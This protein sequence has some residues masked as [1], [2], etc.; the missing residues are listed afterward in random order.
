MSSGN[1]GRIITSIS[2]ALLTIFFLTTFYSFGTFGLLNLLGVRTVMQIFIILMFICLCFTIQLRITKSKLYGAL[3]F[4]SVYAL[5]SLAHGGVWVGPVEAFLGFF[6]FVVIM[7]APRKHIFKVAKV[8]VF[9]TTFFCILVVIAYL[10]YR[11][12]PQEFSFANF[13]IYDS[14]VGSE[15]IHPGHIVDWLSFT[16]GDGF[17]AG[18]EVSPR[19]KGYSNEP[20]STIVHYLAPAIFA[21]LLGGR[22][23]FLG[24]FILTVSVVAIASFTGHI[25]IGLAL[26]LSLLVLFGRKNFQLSVLV[27]LVLILGVI[28]QLDR[29]IALFMFFGE[30][31]IESAGIDLI[32]RKLG[33]GTGPSTLEVRQSGMVDGLRA[34]VFAPIGYSVDQLGAGAGLL[35]IISANMGWIGVLMA[36][37][38][39]LG[40]SRVATQAASSSSSLRVWFATS[41]LFSIL[42]VS[43][44][45]SGY[46]WGRLPGWMLLFLFFRIFKEMSTSPIRKLGKRAVSIK[47]L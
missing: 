44:F 14:T 35:Y 4:F 11:V 23:A 40:L 10:Y 8:L 6:S 2:P 27:S 21:F 42:F 20:S 12:Y 3:I 1:N 32:S 26:L 45:I 31:A 22:L 13:H 29:L 19:M 25:I 30:F 33:S 47:P 46:G 18:G 39:F 9:V 24:I 38:W 37:G 5:G 16:S 7:S 43:L 41:L 36:G 34:I 28:T 17:V 15:R